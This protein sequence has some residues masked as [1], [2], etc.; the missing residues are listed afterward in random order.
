M[1]KRKSRRYLAEVKHAKIQANAST[2]IKNKENKFKASDI[3]VNIEDNCE[4]SDDCEIP[5]PSDSVD[6]DFNLRLAQWFSA[7]NISRYAANELL[8]LLSKKIPCLPNDLR[9][10]KSTPQQVIKGVMPPG[11]YIHYGIKDA[12]TDFLINYSYRHPG[13]DHPSAAS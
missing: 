4:F 10:L 11:E 1:P 6:D 9:T 5:V 8:S 12:L 7:N 13:E 3:F 2:Q